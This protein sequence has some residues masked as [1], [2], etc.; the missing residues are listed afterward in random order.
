M[1]ISINDK[2]LFSL[3][4]TKKQVIANDID[5]DNLDIDLCQRLEW[6]L[7]HKYEQ[8]FKRLK[9][10]WD[11]KLKANGVSMIPIDN[12][13]YAE[14]VFNQPNYKDRKRRDME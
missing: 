5:I 11:E 8:C 13:A 4:K 1:K 10:E 7:M 2:E 14:L 9:N 12:D 3:S 6:V